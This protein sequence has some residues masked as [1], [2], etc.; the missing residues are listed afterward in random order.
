VL[1]AAEVAMAL[2]MFAVLLVQRPGMHSPRFAQ[3]HGQVELRRRQSE[4][5]RAAE[6]EYRDT[7]AFVRFAVIK[8]GAALYLWGA[9]LCIVILSEPNN[10]GIEHVFYGLGLT[11]QILAAA[12]FVVCGLRLAGH[13]W[14][15]VRKVES[16]GDV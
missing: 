5:A 7:H 10:S 8:P 14:N 4:V 3:E 16:Q 1:I 13:I 6:H 9:G 2:C 11:L 15:A 12:T